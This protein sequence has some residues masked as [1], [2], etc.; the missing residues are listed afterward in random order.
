MDRHWPITILLCLKGCTVELRL[1]R[2]AKVACKIGQTEL[3]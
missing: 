3:E 2:A 1:K